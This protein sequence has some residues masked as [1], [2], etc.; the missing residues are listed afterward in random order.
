MAS[1]DNTPPPMVKKARQ[2]TMIV[3]T[4]IALVSIGVLF[5]GG[6]LAVQRIR[7]AANRMSSQGQMSHI[8]HAFHCYHETYGGIPTD[9]YSADGK[10]LLSWRVLLL[11]FLEEDTLSKKFKLDEPWDSPNNK[12]LLYQMPRPYVTPVERSEKRWSHRTYYRGF[13]HKG[14][15]FEKRPL[16]F[17]K[18]GMP[19]G[20][21]FDDFRDGLGKT[22][23]IVEAG[24]PIEWTKPED[25]DGSDGKPF[26]PLGGVIPRIS[27][28]A[29]GM[30][31]GKVRS[32]DRTTSET[33]LRNSTT[34]A[35]GEKEHLD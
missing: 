14:A 23:L 28:F 19:I 4:V 12:P 1:E 7:D 24:E 26:P 25:L 13:S 22:I 9:V 21:S 35:G 3:A 18:D 34:Y 6:Y 30:C 2:R 29:V 8:G 31:D 32:V 5:V 33:L 17:G 11:P 15:I 27:S 16:K 20:P 10:P